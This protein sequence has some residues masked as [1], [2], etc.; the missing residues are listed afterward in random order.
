M[1]REVRNKVRCKKPCDACIDG[2]CMWGNL[3]VL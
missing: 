2:Y 1:K 3:T